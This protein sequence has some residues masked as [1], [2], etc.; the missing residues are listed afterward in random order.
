MRKVS[1]PSE[2]NKITLLEHYFGKSIKNNIYKASH[3]NAGIVMLKNSISVNTR[4]YNDIIDITVSASNAVTA[5]DIGLAVVEEL[6]KIQ[7]TNKF[8]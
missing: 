7:K 5:V 8:L 3:L 1:S 6:D 2:K 4:R